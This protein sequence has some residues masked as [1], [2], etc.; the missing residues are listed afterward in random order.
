[1]VFYREYRA[2]VRVGGELSQDFVIGSMHWCHRVAIQ[3]LKCMFISCYRGALDVAT[4]MYHVKLISSHC[5]IFCFSM[6]SKSTS[7]NHED[8]YLKKQYGYSLHAINVRD[9]VMK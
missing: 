7:K 8:G 6:Y 2:C 3:K 5:K 1:M 9:V 4:L